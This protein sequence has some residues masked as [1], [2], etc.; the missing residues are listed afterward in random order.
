MAAF[1]SRWQPIKV[2]HRAIGN[3]NILHYMNVTYIRD[4]SSH[5]HRHT[6]YRSYLEGRLN[7]CLN[8][9]VR[10][11][12]LARA[13]FVLLKTWCVLLPPQY[14]KGCHTTLRRDIHLSQ[15]PVKRIRRSRPRVGWDVWG[16]PPVVHCDVMI[17]L[18]NFQLY[19]PTSVVDSIQ[20]NRKRERKINSL[21]SSTKKS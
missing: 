18:I 12:V 16:R 8:S 13:S 20:G 10:C 11:T 14:S 15:Q 19:S 2:G 21:H 4:Y 6:A 5:T 7:T 1:A 9:V 3:T 17:N